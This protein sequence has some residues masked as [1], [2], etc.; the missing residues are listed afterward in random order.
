MGKIA[1]QKCKKLAKNCNQDNIKKI[2]K[3]EKTIVQILAAQ[4]TG[5]LSALKC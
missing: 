2:K 1:G 3:L 4:N 5:F